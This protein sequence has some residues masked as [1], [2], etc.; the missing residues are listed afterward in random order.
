MFPCKVLY[1]IVI[2][3]GNYVIDPN[4]ICNINNKVTESTM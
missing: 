3:S 2:H 4:I 1:Y